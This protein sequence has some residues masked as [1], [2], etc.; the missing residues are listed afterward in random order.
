MLHL[1]WLLLIGY[2]DSLFAERTA[3]TG[4]PLGTTPETLN[5]L[6]LQAMRHHAREAALLTRAGER[7]EPMP[8]WRFDRHVIR[9]AL[10]LQERAG[11]KP[12]DRI[13]IVSEWSPEWLVAECAG[14]NL[15]AVSVAVDPGLAEARLAGALV[16]A[17]AKVVFASEPALA[18]LDGGT[19]ALPGLGEV[20]ALGPRRPAENV[21]TLAEVLDLG[22]TLDTAERAQAFR[23]HARSIPPTHPA[24]CHH[25]SSIEGRVAWQE[26]SQGEA[27][28][29]IAQLWRARPARE[30]DRV[31]LAAPALSLALRLTLHA[32]LGDGYS[33][34][35]L[36]TPDRVAAELA[37]LGPQRIIAPPS[38][39][40]QIIRSVRSTGPEPENAGGWRERAGRVLQR[41]GQPPQES[42]VRQALGGRVR[43]IDPMG[44]LDPALAERL[45]RV[46]AVGPELA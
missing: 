29:R 15:G 41:R 17:G 33:L 34:T 40:E 6:Y 30:G 7:W 12:G 19:L 39:L 23:A 38:A 32:C 27:V 20:I 4:K 18:K 26:L 22:G 2:I 8:D 10:Y 42:P 46:A 5:Q 21:R 25:D 16:E 43:A 36:G 24:L 14:L 35:V 13:A 11:L 45:R 1:E 44:A 9:V 28:S 31:Y 37:E 3:L